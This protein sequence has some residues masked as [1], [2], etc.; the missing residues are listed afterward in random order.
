MPATIAEGKKLKR[1]IKVYGVELPIIVTLTHE[2]IEFKVKSAKMGVGNMWAQLIHKGCVTPDN[3][4]SYLAG[5]PLNFL[6]E[7][8]KA[9]VKRNVKRLDKAAKKKEQA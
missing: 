6:I 1:V 9:I 7:Q 5:L 8:A 4:P 3:V 2:G